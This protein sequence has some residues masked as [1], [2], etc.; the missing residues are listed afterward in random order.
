MSKDAILIPMNGVIPFNK[1][2]K[3]REIPYN[4]GGNPASKES[5]EAISLIDVLS[6]T[7]DW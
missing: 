1:F 6:A 7:H 3:E 5:F 2:I 4:N